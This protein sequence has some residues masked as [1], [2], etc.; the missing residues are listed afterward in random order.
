MSRKRPTEHGE[1]WDGD[2]TGS[3]RR[4]ARYA[5]PVALVGVTAVAAALVPAMANAGSPDLPKL[6]AEQLITRIAESETEQLSGTVKVDTDLGLP[7]LPGMG[8]GSGEGG[9]SAEPSAKLMELWSGTHTLRVA[10][11]GP[12]KQRVAIIDGAQEYSLIHNADQVWA[13]DSAS[14]SV[15]HATA[16]EGAGPR[17]HHRE[18]PGTTPRELARQALDAVDETTSVTVD[19]TA[20]VA[21]RDAY[22]LLIKPKQGGSTIGSLRIA[23]DADKGVPLRV[24]L[25]PSDGGKPAVEA[26]FTSVDFSRPDA[27][28]FDFTPPKGAKVTEHEDSGKRTGKQRPEPAL[29]VIGDG[30]TSVLRLEAPELSG[31][32]KQR[33]IPAEGGKLL[34]SLGEKVDG[35]FGT[36][37]LL[38]TRLVNA[39]LTEDGAV[40]AGAVDKETLV[41][42]ADS[43][44]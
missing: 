38:K 20:R 1:D 34:D 17:Q 22:Q 10:A 7:Q 42:A 35:K 25:M 37:R 32:V 27:K 9:S 4:T 33:E 29:D 36:G 18:L 43:A 6:S 3:R 12:D 8:A 15:Y 14:N 44:R 30:W 2:G 19:G 24:T 13:Y 31:D 39:L 41:K 23:V 5:L 11:D 40:Y 26:G 28:S 21:G 16:D